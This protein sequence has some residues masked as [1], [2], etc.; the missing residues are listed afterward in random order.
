L[1][2]PFTI[3]GQPAIDSAQQR[4]CLVASVG[5]EYF[6]TMRIP[7]RDGRGI[8]AQDGPG[9]PPVAVISQELAR[10]YIPGENPL[11]KRL[12][13]KIGAEWL[14]VVG[15]ATDFH[16]HAYD[17]QPRPMV[18]VPYPQMPTESLDLALRVSGRDAAALIPAARAMVRSMD[19]QQPVYEART[20][21][22]LIEVWELFGMRLAAHMMGA[23][24]LLALV[25][26]SVGLYG[27]LSYAVRQRTHEIGVRMALGA[28]LG[29]VQLWV[30]RRG[31]ILA[32]TG[33]VIG[34][35][36]SFAVTQAIASLLYGIHATDPVTFAGASLTLLTIALIASYLPAWRAARVDPNQTLRHE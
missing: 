35:T 32:G 18:Y 19:P 12:K 15:V 26:A 31:L 34:L 24:G 6:R 29:A 21:T 2:S 4:F 17:R 1:G 23:L 27:V 22:Q 13:L 11:G 8:T 3:E 36:S 16:Q 14:T 20:L 10:R 9:T 5:P 30:V 28:T 33:L 7:L 25:L